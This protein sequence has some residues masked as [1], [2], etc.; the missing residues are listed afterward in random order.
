MRHADVVIEIAR[1]APVEHLE[2]D[3]AR[4]AFDR[5]RGKARHQPM[6][7]AEPSRLFV[8]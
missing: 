1:R 3:M 7:D 8:T 5:N 2:V 6:A 4:A